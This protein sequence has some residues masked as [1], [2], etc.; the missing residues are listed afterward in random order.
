[1][2]SVMGTNATAAGLALAAANNANLAGCSVAAASGAPLVSAGCSLA[3]LQT[4]ASMHWLF[5]MLQAMQSV[6]SMEA[7]DPCMSHAMP[8]YIMHFDP[9]S[10]VKGPCAYAG[11]WYQ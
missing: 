5:L 11:K 4:L 1:M 2:G 10:N 9:C 8:R 3:A 6:Q 7:G